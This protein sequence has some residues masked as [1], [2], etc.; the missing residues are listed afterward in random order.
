MNDLINVFKNDD[1]V[2]VVSSREVAQNFGKQHKHVLEKVNELVDSIQPAENPARYFIVSEYKDSK[3]EMRKEYLLTRD[4]FSLLVMGFTGKK[5]LDWKLKYIKAFN[6]M[7]KKLMSPDDL[8]PE[9]RAFKEIFDSMV[10]QQ[11]KL[12]ALNNELEDIREI[13]VFRP[14]TFRKDVNKL[15]RR[16][17]YSKGDGIYNI[18]GIYGESYKLL[19]DRINVDL[20]RRI[21]YKR[22]RMMEDGISASKRNAVNKIDVIAEDKKVT[23]VYVAILKELAIKYGVTKDNEIKISNMEEN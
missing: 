9:L 6:A 14:D 7:E 10:D 20:D 16:I 21:K 2:M 12:N 15:V 1:G 3:G 11:R 23:E 22:K 8:T 18:P 13:T 5:A 17:A 19:E 4:G